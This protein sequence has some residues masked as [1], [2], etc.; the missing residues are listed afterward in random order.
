MKSR[1]CEQT[2]SAHSAEEV[3]ENLANS[4]APATCLGKQSLRLMIRRKSRLVTLSL[5]SPCQHPLQQPPSRPR[6]RAGT[7]RQEQR[8]GSGRT[9]RYSEAESTY[10]IAWGPFVNTSLTVKDFESAQH[11]REISYSPSEWTSV[12]C[13]N[14][15]S[16]SVC[17]HKLNQTSNCQDRAAPQPACHRLFHTASKPLAHQSEQ[18]HI[19]SDNDENGSTQMSIS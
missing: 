2:A 10:V 3:C 12:T 19:R 8:V 6:L 14:K 5:A 17:L 4:E 15:L 9:A 16:S 1:C 13:N 11:A 7:D 18:R